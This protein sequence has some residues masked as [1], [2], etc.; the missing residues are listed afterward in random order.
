MTALSE[1]I[2]QILLIGDHQY[3]HHHFTMRVIVVLTMPTGY[4]A[5]RSITTI[6]LVRRAADSILTE[7]PLSGSS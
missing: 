1:R 4:F 7:V 5:R 3:E 2:E 6:L